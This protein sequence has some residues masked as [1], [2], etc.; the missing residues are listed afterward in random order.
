LAGPATNGGGRENPGAAVAV[1]EALD[2]VLAEIAAVGVAR[3]A[4]L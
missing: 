4:A 2:A 1:V 3:P